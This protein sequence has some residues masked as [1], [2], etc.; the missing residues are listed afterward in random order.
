MLVYVFQ[1][2]DDVR[3]SWNVEETAGSAILKLWKQKGDTKVVI[4]I[5]V[6]AQ[7]T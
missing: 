1:T 2:V 7:V 6:T 3:K 5:D 4:T